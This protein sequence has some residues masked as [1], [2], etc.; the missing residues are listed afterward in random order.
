MSRYLIELYDKDN[1]IITE[2]QET[3][4]YRTAVT[5]SRALYNVLQ[6]SFVLNKNNRTPEPPKHVQWGIQLPYEQYDW[7]QVYDTVKRKVIYVNNKKFT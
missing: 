6:K 7:V 1:D 3:K 4:S 5:I 2:V